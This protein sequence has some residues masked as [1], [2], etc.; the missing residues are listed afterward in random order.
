MVESRRERK[1]LQIRSQLAEAA[2][3]L[4]S[5]QGYE[6]TTVAQIAAAADVATKT[7]FNHFPTKEDVVFAD[8]RQNSEVPLRVIA[9]R[10]PDETVVDLLLRMY[11]EMRADYV[12]HG[13]HRGDPK[14][15]AT[16]AQLI[17]NE[18]ALQARALH[19]TFEL[20]HEI[21]D[22]LQKEYPNELDP[23]TAA[24]VVGAMAGG[25]QAA[26]LKSLELR[27]PE[28]QFWAAMSRGLQIG[29]RG[30]PSQ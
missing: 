9:S 19:K 6:R 25:T 13:V 2:I 14:L 15:M 5:E 20:Q 12:S 29:L 21:A 27:E 8:S 11:E 22:A 23:I 28:E 26:A 30:L 7:F 10:R 4:F 1:K 24:A 17:I 16:Y 18:P 3:R